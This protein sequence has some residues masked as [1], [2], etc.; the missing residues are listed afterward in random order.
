MLDNGIE[1]HSQFADGSTYT[2][3]FEWNGMPDSCQVAGFMRKPLHRDPAYQAEIDALFTIGRLIRERHLEAFIYVELKFESWKR[4]IGEMAFDA[5][6]GCSIRHCDAPIERSRFLQG[7]AFAYAIKGGKEDRKAGRDTS[8]SQI[9]FVEWLLSLADKHVLELISLRD[10]LK[11]TDFEIESLHNLPW[12]HSMCKIAQSSEN[13]PDMLHLWAAQR[14]RMDAFLTLES[15]LPNIAAHFPKSKSCTPSFA[16]RVLRPLELLK[17]LG[18]SSLDPVPI[19]PGL[20]YPVV[21]RPFPLEKTSTKP[22]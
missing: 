20:F 13:Y 18:I 5:L 9:R 14:N 7:D 16:T 17:L 8:L 21:G 12:L 19:Q 15:R 6:A 11:L 10:L 1:S 4:Y 22:R 3:H 2:S